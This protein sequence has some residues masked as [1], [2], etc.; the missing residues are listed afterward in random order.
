MREL[1]ERYIARAG[2]LSPLEVREVRGGRS[3][4]LE[5][6]KGE[7]MSALKAAAAGGVAVLVTE[8]GRGWKSR[9]LSAWLAS[10]LNHG[11]EATWFLCG[12]EDGF[13][14]EDEGWARETMKLS[15]FTLPHELARV[16]LAEQ[17]YRALSI[18]RNVKYHK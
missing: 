15:D 8:R 9:E 2:R 12:G 3:A 4:D 11:R 16:V 14:R 18:A 6:R 5:R 7:D 10:R 17:V 13:R 1:A